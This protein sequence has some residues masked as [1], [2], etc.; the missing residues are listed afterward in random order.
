MQYH[1]LRPNRS[2]FARLGAETLVDADEV[3]RAAEEPP[4][5]TRAYFRGR[6]LARWP[7]RIVAANWDSMVFD[8]GATALQRVPMMEPSRGTLDHVGT[9]LE[10]CETVAELL[11][12]LAD[13]QTIDPEF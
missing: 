10:E 1:D 12:R 3:R 2:L 4:T 8:T 9:L 11:S 13:N 5:D 6:C 7:D